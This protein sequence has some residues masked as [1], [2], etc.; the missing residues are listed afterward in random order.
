MKDVILARALAFSGGELELIAQLG[1]EERRRVRR[2]GWRA[3]LVGEPDQ[4]APEAGE[5]R[6]LTLVLDLLLE[7]RGRQVAPEARDD[8]T[9]ARLVAP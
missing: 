2:R 3:R 7:R 4:P 5:P 6:V 1:A 9:L 8:E